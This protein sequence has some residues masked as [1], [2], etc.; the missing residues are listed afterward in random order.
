[1]FQRHRTVLGCLRAG[2]VNASL[3]GGLHGTLAPFVSL[4]RNAS[5]HKAGLQLLHLRGGCSV[6]VGLGV[7]RLLHSRSGA[8]R[9]IFQM[10]PAL[11]NS[12]V[13]R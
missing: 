1:M 6:L 9:D 4:Y 13:S 2:K 10:G 3:V 7:C 8:D 11:C 12:L 5:S